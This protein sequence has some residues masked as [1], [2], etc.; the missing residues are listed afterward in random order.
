M[1]KRN[2]SDM[3][4][5]RFPDANIVVA[6]ELVNGEMTPAMAAVLETR[7]RIRALRDD[8]TDPEIEAA[9]NPVRAAMGGIH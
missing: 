2:L 7:N 9:I 8:A 4:T 3:L 1:N 6:G 5:D